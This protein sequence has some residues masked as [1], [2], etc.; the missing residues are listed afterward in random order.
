MADLS[1]TQEQDLTG[2]AGILQE[3][4]ERWKACKEFQG[5]EDERS[6]QDI[7]FAHGDARNAW[8]WPDKIYAQRTGTEGDELPCL[9]INNV[10][11]H[12]DL[13]I[14]QICKNDYAPNV[15][16]TSGKASYESAK[17]MQAL[18]RRIK[19]ISAYSTH[20]RKVCEH[21][22]DG[23]I[24]Y[25]LLETRYI[26]ATSRNQD[27]FVKAARDPTAVY[28]DPWITEPD[29]SD[30]NFGFVFELKSRKEFNR[31]YPKYKDIVGATAISSEFADWLT[32]KTIMLGRYYRKK[33]SE[34]RLVWFTADDGN[35]IEKLAATIKEESGDDI[36]KALIAEIA[37]GKRAGG[38]RSVKNDQIEWFL[39]A[40]NKIVERGDWAGR[41]IPIIRAVGRELVIDNTLDR[42]GLTRSLID[43]QRMLNYSSSV[44]VEGVAS[45][46]KSQWLASKR[47]TE[48]QEAWKSANIKRYA[49]LE[50]NDVD[51]EAIGELQKIDPPQRIDPPQASP[52][53]MNIAQ[54]AERH[55]MIAS[56]QWQSETGQPATQFPESGKAITERKQQGDVSTYHF[57]EHMTDAE[58]F[59]AVQLLDLM[60]KIYDTRRALHVIGEDGKKFWLM[61]DPN[62]ENVTQEIQEQKIDEEAIKLAFNPKLGEYQVIAEPGQ[63]FP[64]AREEAVNAM[65]QV[66]A[67]SKEVALIGVDL[68]F[69]YMDWPGAQEL[70]ERWQ[71]E[72]K[73][74]KPYLFDTAN[75][76]RLVASEQQNKRLI[77]TNAE[78][79]Q[80]LAD[81]TLRLRGR[82]ELRDVEAFN[83]D[84]KR[85]DVI[86]RYL[87]KL[88]PSPAMQAEMNHELTLAA[89]QHVYSMVEQANASRVSNGGGA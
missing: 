47:A 73:Y 21:Q 74:T 54:S 31:R 41:Y 59:L 46:V 48:G 87:E 7:K 55:M 15:R 22:V 17:M 80:K 5:V 79:M 42:K 10:R 60:P 76:P 36:Y 67:S 53:W 58:R 72:L 50:Y 18:M 77:S 38:W 3:A 16:P 52:G 27:I 78:L 44:L 14:N 82:D 25:F 26:S 43:P 86:V 65:T 28:L 2:D 81:L 83:A 66:F 20:K 19:Y 64:T 69:K 71:R 61:V 40:G 88:M 8:Q 57:V 23:G 89:H 33:Q 6:R 75:D 45:Q 56:G 39:I 62:L 24:G 84:T 51:D 13:I 70:H 34:D 1:L 12:N 29:G 49:V 85:I 9:T 63:D 37:E 11:V 32:D 68:L 30:A 35:E 4:S